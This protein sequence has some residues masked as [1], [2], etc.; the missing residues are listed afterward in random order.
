MRMLTCLLLVGTI[1]LL[2]AQIPSQRDALQSQY[3]K[4][5]GNYTPTL[6]KGDQAAFNEGVAG[7]EA[8]AKAI[9]Q[10]NG[11][12]ISATSSRSYPSDIKSTQARNTWD[13]KMAMHNSALRSANQALSSF[14]APSD[15]T[16]ASIRTVDALINNISKAIATHHAAC[17]NIR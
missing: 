11:P 3:L 8:V 6:K 4:A 9:I 16:P 10:A 5:R 17:L 14:A 2:G 15:M 13:E 1:S 7:L 12:A